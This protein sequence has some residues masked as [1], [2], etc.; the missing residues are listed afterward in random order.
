MAITCICILITN[1]PFFSGLKNDSAPET[2]DLKHMVGNE[3]NYFPVKYIKIVPLQSWGPSFN[4]SIWH[5]RLT[6]TDDVEIVKSSTEWFN[7]V[8]IKQNI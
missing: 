7:V 4:F 1:C 5:V 6:G 2:F 3:E 8:N